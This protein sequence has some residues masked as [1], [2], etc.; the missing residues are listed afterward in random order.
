M[1]IGQDNSTQTFG[2]THSTRES[3][4]TRFKLLNVQRLTF[5]EDIEERLHRRTQELQQQQIKERAI[6][7]PVSS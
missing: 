3:N 2:K 6:A 5:P 4:N 1:Q 7:T